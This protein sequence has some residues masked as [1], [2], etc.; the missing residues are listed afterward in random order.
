MELGQSQ[1]KSG[2]QME[3]VTGRQKLLGREEVGQH[4]RRK[5]EKEH[6]TK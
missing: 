1:Q 4:L 5:L 3:V 6:T 2:I